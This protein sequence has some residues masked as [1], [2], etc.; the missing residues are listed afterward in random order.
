MYDY[1]IAIIDD[2]QAVLKTLKF[3][4]KGVFA[5]VFTLPHPHSLPALLE[6][7]KID[8][9]LLDMNFSAQKLDG[10]E[11]LCWLRYIKNHPNPPAVVLI[12]AFG[13]INLAVNSMHEGAED[14]VTKPWDNEELIKK[15]L[16]AIEKREKQ[17]NQENSLNEANELKDRSA[18]TRMMTL[19]EVEKQHI[20]EV[21]KECEGNLAEASTRLNI[22]RQTL[23]NK[24]KKYGVCL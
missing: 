14:F 5:K 15:L 8:A 4:L 16:K 18:C 11:G 13:D 23:Y 12:T 9:I 22:S 6:S 7:E 19:D 3:V 17:R 20:I 10:E 1:N 24:L 2:N 21:M